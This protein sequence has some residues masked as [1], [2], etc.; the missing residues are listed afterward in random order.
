MVVNYHQV[1]EKLWQRFNVK[2]PACHAWYYRQLVKSLAPLSDTDA[3]QEF[4]RL[5]DQVFPA[6]K[7]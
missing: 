6:D 2:D 7:F 3:Y 5:V 4:A 1:G